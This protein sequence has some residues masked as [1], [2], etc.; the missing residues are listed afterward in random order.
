MER[1]YAAAEAVITD[2]NNVINVTSEIQT[3]I[4]GDFNHETIDW[5]SLTSQ[6][7][8][9]LFFDLV[10]DSFLIHHVL[11]PTRGNSILDFG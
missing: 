7:E 10:Q 5:I 4:M 1:C 9:E 3:L 8:G 11:E 2:L 6:A